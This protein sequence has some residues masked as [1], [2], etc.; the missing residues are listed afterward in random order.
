M[1]C[2]NPVQWILHP[3]HDAHSAMYH[4]GPEAGQFVRKLFFG[5]KSMKINL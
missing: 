2:K 1:R 4:S 3:G 5:Q